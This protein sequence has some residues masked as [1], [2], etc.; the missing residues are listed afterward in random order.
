MRSSRNL[1]AVAC[2]AGTLVTGPLVTGSVE[3]GP[4]YEGFD[5]SVPPALLIGKNG[6]TG[7]NGAWDGY[8]GVDVNVGAGLSFGGLSTVPGGAVSDPPNPGFNSFY[9]RTLAEP[10]GADN[11][12]VYLS[13][14][15]RPSAGFGFYGGVNLEGL[16]VGKSGPVDNYSI[17]DS[18][19]I[20]QSPVAAAAGTTVFLVL[21][22]EFGALE[23]KFS[24]YVNPTPGGTEPLTPDAYKSGFDSVGTIERLYINNAGGWTTDEIRIGATWAE[25][26]PL[27]AVPEPATLGLLAAGLP[28]LALFL[29]RKQPA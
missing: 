6:G 14:L 3:A 24:L 28:G 21:R 8:Y 2:L 15:L 9:F 1:L 27:S 13:F 10:L 20:D 4:V 25:V 5:Y 19:G 16:F 17:E 7:W 12:T 22:A 18:H 29:R 26:T 23:D 11:T